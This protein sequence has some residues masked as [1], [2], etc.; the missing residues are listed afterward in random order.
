M[1]FTA[2]VG[3]LVDAENL[4]KWWRLHNVV[5]SRSGRVLSAC[6]EISSC[7]FIV[8]ITCLCLRKPCTG[9]HVTWASLAKEVRVAG[10]HC[11]ECQPINVSITRMS[12][13]LT[14]TAEVPFL[15]SPR[16]LPPVYRARSK[17]LIDIRP[18]PQTLR[19]VLYFSLTAER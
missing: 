16:I 18:S 4:Y 14:F 2:I 7:T 12:I 6:T 8:C 3:G 9:R 11:G 10:C 1:L 15:R 5:A 17:R 19:R 13:S